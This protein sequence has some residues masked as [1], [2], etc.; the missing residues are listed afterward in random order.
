MPV[1]L[2]EAHGS[3]FGV[4]FVSVLTIK[5]FFFYFLAGLGLGCCVPPFSSCVESG[6]QPVTPTKAG[7]FLTT[8]PSGKS[9]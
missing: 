6:V 4:V 2:A 5:K 8:D 3:V 1:R 9:P 7:R